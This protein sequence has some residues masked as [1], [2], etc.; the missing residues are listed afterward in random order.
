M[1]VVDLLF[2]LYYMVFWFLK[3]LVS[4]EDEKSSSEPNESLPPPELELLDIADPLTG[5][6]DAWLAAMHKRQEELEVS[7]ASHQPLEI[8]P[9][10]VQ[11]ATYEG[12]VGAIRARIVFLISFFLTY[13]LPNLP[14]SKWKEK[15]MAANKKRK[16]GTQGDQEDVLEQIVSIFHAMDQ[17]DDTWAWDVKEP[18]T[19]TQIRFLLEQVWWQEKE[20][21]G[22]SLF[23]HKSELFENTIQQA[24]SDYWAAC[25]VLEGRETPEQIESY[26]AWLLERVKREDS[27][28]PGTRTVTFFEEVAPGELEKYKTLYLEEQQKLESEKSAVLSLVDQYIHFVRTSFWVG[29]K[30]LAMYK[31]ESAHIAD[32][33]APASDDLD[34]QYSFYDKNRGTLRRIYG[35]IR[36]ELGNPYEAHCERFF[37]FIESGTLVQDL[38]KP[39]R[40]S[41]AH[42]LYEWE[43]K[44]RS[45]FLSTLQ[46]HIATVKEKCENVDKERGIYKENEALHQRCYWHLEAMSKCLAEAKR[47]R[48]E[49]VIK[50]AHMPEIKTQYLDDIFRNIYLESCVEIGEIHGFLER[51]GETATYFDTTYEKLLEW[52]RKVELG[53]RH[54]LSN[55]QHGMFVSTMVAELLARGIPPSSLS[56]S[57]LIYLDVTTYVRFKKE[58]RKEKK[59]VVY[60]FV[61]LPSV[62]EADVLKKNIE[63]FL[64]WCNDLLVNGISAKM[65]EET[66]VSMAVERV[67]KELFAYIEHH[68]EDGR[69]STS[70]SDR[71]SFY[72]TTKNET[73]CKQRIRNKVGWVLKSLQHSIVTQDDASRLDGSSLYVLCVA[74]KS[75]RAFVYSFDSHSLAESERGNG[76]RV[77]SSLDKATCCGLDSLEGQ[78]FLES[79][80]V[81]KSGISLTALHAMLSALP[82]PVADWKDAENQ[83]NDYVI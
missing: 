17:L 50:L 58:K 4:G 1:L 16:K 46:R 68:Y 12:L 81:G 63:S 37:L 30:T 18:W 72:R 82:L 27:T 79:Y 35:E 45:D 56:V 83:Y 36:D 19:I 51:Y 71:R 2:I 34:S 40:R 75:G 42:P 31:K 52:E 14:A 80:M 25:S 39:Y 41:H 74:T 6:I 9:E 23:D 60:Q 48:E 66:I 55:Q 5:E 26:I 57:K 38:A 54:E 11:S 62:S 67:W 20:H 24:F 59:E 28:S 8:S 7:I 21:D 64:E 33:V 22:T 78:R 44:L 49:L 29:K 65:E 47:K 70:L 15:R 13:I 10:V 61:E 76:L 3:N 32:K 43:Y 69:Y 77:P 73:V 53:A